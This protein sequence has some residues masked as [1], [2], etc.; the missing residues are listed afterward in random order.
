MLAQV[1]ESENTNIT[2]ME[3]IREEREIEEKKKF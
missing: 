2:R 3:I 1:V